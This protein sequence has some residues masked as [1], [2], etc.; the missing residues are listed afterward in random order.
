[1]RPR[2][3]GVGGWHW[4]IEK[5]DIYDRRLRKLQELGMGKISEIDGP[6]I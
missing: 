6:L 2:P 3:S 5:R 4:L 1:M